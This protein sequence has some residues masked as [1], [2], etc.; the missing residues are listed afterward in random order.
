MISDAEHLVMFLLAICMSFFVKK[1][2]KVFTSSTHI[3]IR[4][5]VFKL[6]CIYSVYVLDTNS[7]SNIWFANIFSHS[8]SSLFTFFF[9]AVQKVFS[10]IYSHL[11]LFLVLLLSNPKWIIAK[12]SIENHGAYVVLELYG[13]RFCIQVFNSF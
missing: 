4:L 3:L 2:K 12:S 10:L 11:F 8:I 5:F 13:L 6:S 7:L 9:S 1:K